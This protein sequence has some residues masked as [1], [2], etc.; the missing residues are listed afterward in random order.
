MRKRRKLKLKQLKA[1]LAALKKRVEELEQNKRSSVQEKTFWQE[2]RLEII[3]GVIGLAV[4]L[5]TEY[6]K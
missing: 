1:E 2:V 6:L 5:F 4:A 3:I